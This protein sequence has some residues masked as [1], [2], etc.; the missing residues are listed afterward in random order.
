MNC[1]QTQPLLSE[2]IDNSLSARDTFEVDRH[3]GQ[4]R[5]CEFALHE[6]RRTVQLLQSAPRYEVGAEFMERLN[7]RLM[8]VRPT[9]PRWLWA[10]NLQQIFRPRMLPAWGAL[11][12]MACLVI[13]LANMPHIPSAPVPGSMD[14][15]VVRAEPIAVQDA[16]TQNVTLAASDPLQD[17]S[18]ANLAA[19]SGADIETQGN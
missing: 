17:I 12:A 8:Q 10:Q 18:A 6:M 13:V 2:F 14:A 7:A 11:S 16:R 4:C 15:A 9:A 5:E 3:L 19:H 1:K